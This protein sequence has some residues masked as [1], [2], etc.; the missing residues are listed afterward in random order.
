MSTFH[1]ISI[2]VVDVSPR[3]L[4]ALAL[5]VLPG[6]DARYYD[7]YRAPYPRAPVPQASEEYGS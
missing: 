5:I 3:C 6:W 7:R 2:D 4:L 1:I